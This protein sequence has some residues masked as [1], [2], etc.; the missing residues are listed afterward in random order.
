M[1]E[2]DKFC[3]ALKEAWRRI[4]DSFIKKY[5]AGHSV[6]KT[7]VCFEEPRPAWWLPLDEDLELAMRYNWV[8][9]VLFIRGHHGVDWNGGD[10]AFSIYTT[11]GEFDSSSMRP[12]G[13]Q[14]V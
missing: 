6:D 8:D 14:L 3:N 9:N 5:N 11:P 7:E 10:L 2:K 12:I 1:S 4:P 13:P